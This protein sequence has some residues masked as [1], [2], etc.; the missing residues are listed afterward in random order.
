MKSLLVSTCVVFFVGCFGDTFPKLDVT[1][2]VKA[3][4]G[5]GIDG[6]KVYF[7]HASHTV[8]QEG[9]QPITSTD[10]AGR[11]SFTIG[12]TPTYGGG[13]QRTLV[14]RKDGLKEVSHSL[15]KVEIREARNKASFDVKMEQR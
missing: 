14:F 1:G 12:V 3:P 5:S 10:K 11:F 15:Q 9:D 4:D 2:A 8:E 13:L 6:V 7:I